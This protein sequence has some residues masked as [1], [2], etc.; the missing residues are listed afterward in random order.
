M[1]LRKTP[2]RRGRLSLRKEGVRQKLE[3]GELSLSNIHPFLY[4]I[5]VTF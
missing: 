2:P 3:K 4:E 1:P 5:T